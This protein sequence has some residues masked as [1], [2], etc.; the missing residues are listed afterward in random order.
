M[1][2]FRVC[3][4]VCC[5][6]AFALILHWQAKM[7]GCAAAGW[8]TGLPTTIWDLITNRLWSLNWSLS[9]WRKD[10][11][12]GISDLYGPHLSLRSF[13]LSVCVCVS[14]TWFLQWEQQDWLEQ[15]VQIHRFIREDESSVEDEDLSFSQSRFPSSNQNHN[16]VK[17]CG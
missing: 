15:P 8:P 5:C 6:P 1:Y 12:R 2:M 4:C 16:I 11:P 17:Y 7:N 3:V 13:C 9:Q 14:C 10:I